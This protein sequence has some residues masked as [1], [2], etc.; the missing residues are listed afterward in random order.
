MTYDE[1]PHRNKRHKGQTLVE[2]ALTLPI[3]LMLI[4]GIV[5]FGRAFQAWVTL[6]NAAREAARYTTTGQYDT[7]KYDLLELLP[8]TPEANTNFEQVLDDL[9]RGNSSLLPYRLDPSVSVFVDANGAL[10]PQSIFATYY[11]G[12]NCDPGKAEDFE[13]RKDIVRLASIYDVARRGATGL[14]LEPSIQDGSL[15][16]LFAQLT[17]RWEPNSD[18]SQQAGYFDVLVCSTRSNLNPE[19]GYVHSGS[20]SR[21]HMVFDVTDLPSSSTIPASRQHW[22]RFNP[23]YCLLNEA[24]PENSIV[25]YS[26]LPWI[27][28]GGPG[29]RIT[30]IVTLNHTLLT[31]I[32]DYSYLTMQARR[33]GVNETF[34][35]SRALNA[36]QGGAQIGG[37]PDREP[38]TPLETE[39]PTTDPSEEPT[40]TETEVDPG[41][42]ETP[43]EP[44]TPAPA[45]TC[46]LLEISNI[47]FVYNAVDFTITNRNFKS[48]TLESLRLQ[49]NVP[50]SPDMLL[51][52]SA[53]NNVAHWQSTLQVPP[54]GSFVQFP[55]S[56]SAPLTERNQWNNASRVITGT[57]STGTEYATSRYR[58]VFINVNA[59]PDQPIAAANFSGTQ[60]VIQN[61]DTTA[62]LLQIN[63]ETIPTPPTDETPVVTEE[64]TEYRP[65]CSNNL[66]TV[67]FAP[68]PFQTLGI[69]VLRVE[70]N[71]PEP[72]PLLGVNL[73]WFD[74]L[75]EPIVQGWP[76]QIHDNINQPGQVYLNQIRVGPMNSSPYSGTVAV[77]QANASDRSSPTVNYPGNHVNGSWLANYNFPPYSVSHVYLDFD[78]SRAAGSLYDIGMRTWMLDGDLW[79]DCLLPD[80]TLYGGHNDYNDYTSFNDPAPPPPTTPT[81]PPPDNPMIRVIRGTSGNNDMYHEGTWTF[82]DRNR[83]SAGTQQFRLINIG[84]WGQLVRDGNI[85]VTGDTS[86]ITISAGA[87][88]SSRSPGEGSNFTVRCEATQIGTHSVTVHIKSNATNIPHYQFTVRCTTK[89]VSPD[90]VVQNRD[91]SNA[92]ISRNNSPRISMNTVYVGQTSTLRLRVRNTGTSPSEYITSTGRNIEITGP[93]ADKFTI[94]SPSWS[95]LAGAQNHNFEV[96]CSSPTSGT[97]NATVVVHNNVA[98]KNPY[99][100]NVT[101]RVNNVPTTT[102]TATATATATQGA[103]EEDEGGPGGGG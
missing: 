58:A 86:R 82:G 89:D 99:N 11:D 52:S 80:G 42:E 57:E 44:I 49:W 26:G 29:D 19:A 4:F 72:S 14:N 2:F 102:E 22:N 5:E 71:R 92:N 37:F 79:I 66:L 25:N 76:S 36:V 23:P 83:N 95:Q 24:P 45:F 59:N 70:N 77:W 20:S 61:Y 6:E 54:R 64:P 73:R 9:R 18:R 67:D 12:R 97:F 75:P 33:S 100:V 53:L 74:H 16:P 51:T 101:C 32:F 85:Y 62:C 17:E 41:G 68:N 84:D 81:D 40:P 93:N 63:A 28:A 30:V 98:G 56:A 78:G 55:P 96:R 10:S 47:S 31:P 39:T 15:Y 27:D 90:I 21:F 87:N 103:D 91:N 8:C 60:I 65:D 13:L 3:L 69:V 7:A 46:D 50:H 94:V 1:R 35:T 48:G 88:W 38:G 34:R 43:T